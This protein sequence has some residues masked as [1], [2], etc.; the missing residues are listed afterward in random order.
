MT[1]LAGGTIA[2]GTT[3]AEYKEK[4]AE[5]GILDKHMHMIMDNKTTTDAMRG[6]RLPEMITRLKKETTIPPDKWYRIL[7]TRNSSIALLQDTFTNMIDALRSTGIQPK[8]FYKI[9]SHDSTS[10][11]LL[12]DKTRFQSVIEALRLSGIHVVKWH[13]VLCADHVVVAISK[14][15]LP[16]IIRN[17]NLDRCSQDEWH[18][19]M[20]MSYTHSASVVTSFESGDLI[21]A[22]IARPQQGMTNQATQ[23]PIDAALDR[24]RK[25]R[26]ASKTL[27]PVLGHSVQRS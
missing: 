26:Q 10:R 11:L 22:E 20:V 3:L 16:K 23:D 14:G 21:A 12:E 9:L 17:M 8:H 15:S 6:D 18:T 13:T 27:R 1:A 4:L 24:L 2:G 19:R 7:A 5:H 25:A